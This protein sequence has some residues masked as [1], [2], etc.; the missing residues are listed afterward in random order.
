VELQKVCFF[1]NTEGPLCLSNFEMRNS[2]DGGVHPTV[3][4]HTGTPGK[5]KLTA[6]VIYRFQGA[7][8]ETNKTTTT[9]FVH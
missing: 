3:S 8:Y 9:I 5:Y 2:P 4:L 6:M 1:W 7:T